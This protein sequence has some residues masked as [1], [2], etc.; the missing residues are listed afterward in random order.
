MKRDAKFVFVEPRF[1]AYV[2]INPGAVQVR[3][4]TIIMGIPA[5]F[6][7][8]QPF[9]WKVQQFPIAFC[10]EWELSF[11]VKADN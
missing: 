5:A 4:R 1:W 10:H 8:N 3:I 6:L 7:R 2:P 11:V 9:S